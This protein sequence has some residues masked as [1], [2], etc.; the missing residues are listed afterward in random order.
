MQPIR[1]W[2]T[3][4]I[5]LFRI[6]GTMRHIMLL[7]PIST[8]VALSE[9][10]AN[11]LYA[12]ASQDGGIN[13]PPISWNLTYNTVANVMNDHGIDWKYYSG[14]MIDSVDCH[15][16]DRTVINNIIKPQTGNNW[17]AYWNVLNNFPSIQLN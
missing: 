3:T 12:V 10:Y 9:S 15:P 11:H 16:F 5:G 14:S 7:T 13:G 8:R 1:R 4:R 6:T 17:N 2:T